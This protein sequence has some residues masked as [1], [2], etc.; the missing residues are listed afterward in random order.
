MVQSIVYPAAQNQWTVPLAGSPFTVP[1]GTT[2]IRTFQI[3]ADTRTVVMATS[4]SQNVQ[5]IILRGAGSQALL[6]SY[7]GPPTSDLTAFGVVPS[8]DTDIIGFFTAGPNGPLTVYL[9]STNDTV[10]E[11]NAGVASPVS[12]VAHAGIVGGH[13]WLSSYSSLAIRDTSQHILFDTGPFGDVGIVNRVIKVNLN[14]NQPIALLIGVQTESGMVLNGGGD[15]FMAMV[16]FTLN[17]GTSIANMV[18]KDGVFA[19]GGGAITPAGGTTA[20]LADPA[21]HLIIAATASVAPISG[22]VE[23]VYT[24]QT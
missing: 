19:Y 18:T 13:Q 1:A 21:E 14:L 7:S 6:A 24:R 15:Y 2:V 16:N 8:I 12:G 11:L 4:P 23:L 3:N 5:S 22:T 17:G 9:S 20:F 10:S